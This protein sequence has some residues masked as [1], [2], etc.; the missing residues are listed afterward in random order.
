MTGIRVDMYQYNL[1]ASA[2]ALA[3]NVLTLEILEHQRK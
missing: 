3:H 2:D 1:S